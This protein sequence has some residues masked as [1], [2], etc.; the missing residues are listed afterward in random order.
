MSSFLKRGKREQV[1][2]DKKELKQ[3]TKDF[4]KILG[5]LDDV[6]KLIDYKYKDSKERVV[7]E[8]SIV[9]LASE[10]TDREIGSMEKFILLGK[11]EQLGFKDLRNKNED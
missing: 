1:R 7:H 8:D 5:T 2:K 9:E 11:L 3:R 4:Y 6:A 10:F